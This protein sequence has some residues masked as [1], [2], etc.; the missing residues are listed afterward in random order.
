MYYNKRIKY[1]V[2]SMSCIVVII[3]ILSGMGVI[4]NFELIGFCIK[5]M[6]LELLVLAYNS[7]KL[8]RKK[9]EFIA[10]SITGI[11]ILL[12]GCMESIKPLI[13][14]SWSNLIILGL[15][16]FLVIRFIKNMLKR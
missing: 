9:L 3:S 10:I 11:F 15:I 7:Y 6:A 13:G 16:G 8:G 1:L 4:P 12:E 14:I 2:I 5:L